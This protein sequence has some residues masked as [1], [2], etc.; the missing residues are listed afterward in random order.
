VV[1]EANVHE[2]GEEALRGAGRRRKIDV[3]PEPYS[4]NVVRDRE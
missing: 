1:Q 4:P 2:M 3:E